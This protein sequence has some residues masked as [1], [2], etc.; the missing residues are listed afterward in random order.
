MKS[1]FCLKQHSRRPAQDIRLSRGSPGWAVVAQVRYL[2]LDEVG[3]VLQVHL[4]SPGRAVM[5]GQRQAP[6][7][8]TPTAPLPD[9]RHDLL[10]D[11]RTQGDLGTSHSDMGTPVDDPFGSTLRM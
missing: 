9:D 8:V 3:R 2:V 11:T 6:Q 5:G 10:L 4:L 1:Y 7:G